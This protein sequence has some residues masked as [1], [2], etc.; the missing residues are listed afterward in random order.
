M[1]APVPAWKSKTVMIVAAALGMLGAWR[2]SVFHL[3]SLPAESLAAFQSITTY[4]FSVFGLI[5]CWGIGMKNVDRIFSLKTEAASLATTAF[6]EMHE[7]REEK[8]EIVET[9]VIQEMAARYKDD[10]SYRPL[11]TLPDKDVEVFR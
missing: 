10:D 5:I 7:K 6:Q 4:C 2:W 3:Y 9:Q 11:D 1:P 8:V